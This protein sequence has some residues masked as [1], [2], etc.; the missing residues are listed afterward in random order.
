M[1]TDPQNGEIQALVGGRDARYRGYNRAVDAARPVGSL[2]KPAI[3]LTALTDPARY[4]LV[5]PVDDG[6]FVW[7]SRGAPDWEPQ[8]Y[9]NQFR[10]PLRLARLDRNHSA[11]SERVPGGRAGHEPHPVRRRHR[12]G[13]GLGRAAA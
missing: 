2:L 8:N 4:T 11:S 9:D 3:Y 13:E 1:I 7:K 5:T 12:G 10:G 6:P